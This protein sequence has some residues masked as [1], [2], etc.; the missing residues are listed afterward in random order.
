MSTLLL[1]LKGPMQSWGVQS[2]FTERDTLR[3]P[4]KSGVIG[5]VAAAFGRPRDA[6][7]AD[8]A[9]LRMHVRVEREGK[10]MRD[11]H[12]AQ[13]VLRSQTNLRKLHK[14]GR[15]LASEIQDTVVSNRYFL[16][17]AWFTV[18]LEGE[19]DLLE[20]VARALRHPRWPL[21]LGRRAFAPSAPVLVDA[22]DANASASD[23]LV[24][25]VDPYWRAVLNREPDV[26]ERLVLEG[27]T[28]L[29]GWRLVSSPTRP[30]DPISF[31]PRRFAPRTVF[32]Y[33]RESSHQS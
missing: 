4:S 28:S 13:N 17:D 26:P 23:V 25:F 16:S 6:S 8:L 19:H 24:D 31:R 27:E 22:P 3:E 7:I 12:T 20:E 5:L 21:G 9:A 1:R 33:V 29:P 15:P 10:L 30:D 18:A 32:I 14:R 11:F 2:R